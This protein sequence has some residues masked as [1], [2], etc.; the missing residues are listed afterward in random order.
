MI[1]HTENTPAKNTVYSIQRTY[2]CIIFASR[3][4]G[5]YCCDFTLQALN[6]QQ[7]PT[8]AAPPPGYPSFLLAL[9]ARQTAP[10]T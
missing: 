1:V 2:T 10:N 5:Q 7:H 4:N 9:Q 3:A 6:T 8:T